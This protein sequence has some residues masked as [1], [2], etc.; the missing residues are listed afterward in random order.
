M[1]ADRVRR[2][3]EVLRESLAPVELR[4]EDESHQHV[5]HPGARAGGGH[6]RVSIVSARFEGAPR[7]KR[8]RM[9]YDALGDEMRE[10]IHALAIEALTPQEWAEV[11]GA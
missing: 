3:E 4:V 9:I 2:I 8:H 11:P 10:E 6:F 1:S 5:G 7:V